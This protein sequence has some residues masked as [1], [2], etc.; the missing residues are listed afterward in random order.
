MSARVADAPALDGFPVVL[1]TD[2]I[3]TQADSNQFKS[4]SSTRTSHW[5]EAYIASS[6]CQGMD[7]P[8]G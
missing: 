3:G 8:A 4:M 2:S 6:V 7:A 1:F 5:G